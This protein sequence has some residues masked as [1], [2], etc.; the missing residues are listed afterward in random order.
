VRSREAPF[1]TAEIGQRTATICH[2]N[3]IAMRLGNPL[4]WDPVAERTNDDEANGMLTASM[5]SPW[6]LEV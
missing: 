5:R 2:L 1:A 3:N 4:K 6:K